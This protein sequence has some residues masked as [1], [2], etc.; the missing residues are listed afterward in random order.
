MASLFA[1][2]YT[3]LAA[4]HL[5]EEEAQAAFRALFKSK[6]VDILKNIARNHGADDEA[7]K[8]DGMKSNM[9]REEKQ[10]AMTE[11]SGHNTSFM[12]QKR[13]RTFLCCVDGSDAADSAFKTTLHM[14]KK[15]DHVCVFHAYSEEKN[16]ALPASLCYEE[17]LISVCKRPYFSLHFEERFKRTPLRVLQDLMNFYT[18]TYFSP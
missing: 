16:A 4:Q 1:E 18:G 13:A 8:S 9:T 7:P 6:E 3:K 10:R 11:A 2:E 12:L 15:Y 5:S 17:Q 14:K